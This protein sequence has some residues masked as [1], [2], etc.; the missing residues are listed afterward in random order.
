MGEKLYPYAVARIRMLE[1]SLLTEK[2][3][4]QMAEAKNA[5]EAMKI[6]L[7]AG[8]GELGQADSKHIQP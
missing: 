8:Y 3:Y 1:R 5:D 7:E 4:I 2:N 6:L